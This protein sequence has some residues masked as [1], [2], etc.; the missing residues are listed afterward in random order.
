M[1]KKGKTLIITGVILI[2]LVLILAP[3]ILSSNVKVYDSELK[4]VT[5]RDENVKDIAKIKLLTP[6]N[7]QV[8]RGYQKV[9]EYEINSLEA[10]KILVSKMELYDKSDGMKSINR[11]IDYKIK[12]L[13]EVD[14]NNYKT[15]C[16]DKVSFNGTEYNECYQEITRTHK[17]EKVVWDDLNKVDFNKD[18]KIIVGLFTEVQKGDKIEWIPTFKINDTTE[19]RIEEW[20]VWT[21]SLN[22]NLISYWTLNETGGTS[23][24][25]LFG[26]NSAVANNERV[27]T[28]EITGIIDT[29][30]DFTQ[31]DDYILLNDTGKVSVSLWVNSSSLQ[32]DQ[33]FF[34]SELTGSGSA[35]YRFGY[36]ALNVLSIQGRANDGDSFTTWT[37]LSPSLNN[38]IW[39]HLVAI[40]D[41]INGRALIY[42]NGSLRTN[43]SIATKTFTDADSTQGFRLGSYAGAYYNGLADEI[44]IWER[45]LNSTEVSDLYNDGEGL[46]YPFVE[47]FRSP[48]T[49]TPILNSTDG[50]NRSNQ[51]LNCYATLT[52]NYET[53]LTADWKWYKN[54]VSVISGNTMVQNNTETLITILL[55]GN[56]TKGEEW[57]CEVTPFD[58]L[59]Y[60]NASNS[61]YITILNSAPTHSSPLLNTSTGKN[62][63]TEN[64]ICYNQS[65]FDADND[66]VINIY[67]WYK[68]NQPLSVLNLPFE[69]GSNSSYTKD[70]SGYNNVVVDNNVIWKSSGGHNS[71]GAYDFTL[72]GATITIPHSTAVNP[73][74]EITIMAWLKY[75]D[76]YCDSNYG[77]SAA[78]PIAKGQNEAFELQTY[79]LLGGDCTARFCVNSTCPDLEETN[80]TAKG[81]WAHITGSFNG[82]HINTYFNGN[83]DESVAYSGKIPFITDDLIIGDWTSNLGRGFKGIIDEVMIFDYALSAEQIKTFYEGKTNLIVSEE[84]SGG[85]VYMCQ[86]TPNDGEVDGITKNSSELEVL[87]GITFNVRDSYSNES[88]NDVTISCNYSEFNQEGDITNPYGVYGFP[89]GTWECEF[90]DPDIKYYNKTTTFTA[91]DD[92]IV[93]VLMSQKKYLT[94][95]EHTWLEAIYNCISGG[96][97]ALYNLLLEINSTIGNI[98][99]NTKP[100]DE[101]VVL[102]EIITNKVVDSTHNLTINYSI[103]IPIKAGYSLGAYLPVRIGY[104]FLDINN[105]TCYNQGERPEGVSDPYCQPLIIETL[106]PMGGTVNFTVELQPALVSGDNYSIKRIIDIDPLGVWYNYGSEV[107]SD[108]IM[109]ETLSTYGASTTTTGESN[110]N[111]NQQSNSQESS[112]S[113]SESSS[114]DSSV[115]NVYNTYITEEIKDEEDKQNKDELINLNKPGIT[116]G[117]IGTGLFSNWMFIIILGIFMG[118]FVVF[119]ISK[120]IIKLKKR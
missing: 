52:D 30:A 97:C 4:E 3:F 46:P 11:I 101:S 113:S 49:T 100:T 118:L 114:G 43:D 1:N 45:V 40:Y 104:F 5:I 65:T 41:G 22:V 117:I 32:S 105:E 42:I 59:N 75:N 18:E 116:G 81:G 120:T 98:W 84:T 19:I 102:S 82:T 14:V 50:T 63:S 48:Q 37:S 87:W 69:A 92:K 31:G 112:S 6:L 7:Y 103:Y 25:D 61:T 109:L 10:L 62:L 74:D 44:G 21:D 56:T 70:Y 35:R 23:V 89:D 51:D 78:R 57:I 77:G 86:I 9:A 91:D 94:V 71:K 54:N 27:F 107:I 29:G 8:P 39:Y 67:N 16:Q 15:V 20:A 73:T 36:G 115:T 2:S 53:N 83:L 55:W 95:E 108:F 85:D 88:L 66:E 12:G 34:V 90:E 110:P 99:E 106:G 72:D 26:N 96:D 47:D 79:E 60:G 64:L 58:N 119:I 38:N 80:G 17:E 93:P 76:T 68:N 24:L 111:T 13:E 33:N 28:S